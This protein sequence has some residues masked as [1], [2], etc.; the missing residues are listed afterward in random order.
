MSLFISLGVS[1]QLAGCSPQGTALQYLI[2][3]KELFLLEKVRRLLAV[4]GANLCSLPPATAIW[5]LVIGYWTF[6]VKR[7]K[8]KQVDFY[9]PVL[10]YSGWVSP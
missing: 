9:P 5:Y 6:P 7:G 1:G 2:K 8:S 4:T 10:H 3:Q